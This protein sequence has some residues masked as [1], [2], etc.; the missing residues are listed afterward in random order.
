MLL[1]QNLVSTKSSSDGT[2]PRGRSWEPQR[3]VE[4]CTAHPIQLIMSGV[5][6]KVLVGESLFSVFLAQLGLVLRGHHLGG[7][8]PRGSPWLLLPPDAAQ[9]GIS[10]TP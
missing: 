5:R 2:V 1:G 9:L 10:I 6:P 4:M 8:L 3:K 7:V